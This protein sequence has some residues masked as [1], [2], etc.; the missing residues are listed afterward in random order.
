MNKGERREA[1]RE[2]DGGW[3]KVGEGDSR[4]GGEKKRERA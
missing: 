2:K 3:I 1:R 4:R